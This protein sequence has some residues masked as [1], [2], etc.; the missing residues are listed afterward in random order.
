MTLGQNFTSFPW[1]NLTLDGS[2]S[3]GANV[4]YTDGAGK[5]IRSSG[6]W[7]KTGPNL[8]KVVALGDTIIGGDGKE[9]I[10][11]KIPGP[12]S[13]GNGNATSRMVGPNGSFACLIS[14]TDGYSEVITTS[15]FYEP[16]SL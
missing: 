3:I 1:I 2:L 5:I 8:D 9:H 6:I 11:S 7:K 12:A 13:T 14:C 16:Y 4:A 10:V 15:V